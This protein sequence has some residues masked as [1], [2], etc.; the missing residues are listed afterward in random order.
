M[1]ALSSFGR[2]LMLTSGRRHEPC[3]SRNRHLG[4][5]PI[6]C[7]PFLATYS[8]GIAAPEDVI[9]GS[10]FRF[11]IC[12]LQE[13]IWRILQGWPVKLVTV[14]PQSAEH[15]YQRYP[16]SRK[17][18]MP[19]QNGVVCSTSPNTSLQ[20]KSTLAQNCVRIVFVG[21]IEL[22]RK[23][24]DVLIDAVEILINKNLSLFRLTIVGDGPDI[25]LL[26]DLVVSKG[27]APLV[28][29]WGT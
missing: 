28:E 2:F 8:G 15:L 11:W 10:R 7:L 24:L 13:V 21:S 9:R 4:L 27:L 25:S 3:T 23:G 22:D 16:H 17:W 18:V 20:E 19:I 26:R 29:F 14:S 1:V 12:R 5:P 6:A